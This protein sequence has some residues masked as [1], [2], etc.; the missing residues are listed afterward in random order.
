MKRLNQGF[1]NVFTYSAGIEKW[2]ND[3]LP[4]EPLQYTFAGDFA[5]ADWTG[6]KNGVMDTYNR[7]KAEWL[8][9]Y[10]AFTEA[11]VAINMLAWA[12]YNLKKQGYDGRDPFIELYSD[13]Y[14]QAVRD[15]YEKYENDSEAREY[16]YRMTD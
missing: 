8:N 11:A 6:G 16:F 14:H 10:K 9:N 2:I 4:G 1:K 13:L 7:V 3:S 12:H 15:F 5:I